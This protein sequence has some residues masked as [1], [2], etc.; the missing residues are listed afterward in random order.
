MDLRERVDEAFG[1]FLSRTGFRS[2][3]YTVSQI[4]F[5]NSILKF[6]SNDISLRFVT[7]RGGFYVDV[8]HASSAD[9]WLPL[10]FL[11]EMKGYPRDALAGKADPEIASTLEREYAEIVK[12]LSEDNI[13]RTMQAFDHWSRNGTLRAD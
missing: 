4:Y 1:I 6:K 9:T 2:T 11:L 7:D 10:S 3:S 12:L 5:G 13:D 8:A